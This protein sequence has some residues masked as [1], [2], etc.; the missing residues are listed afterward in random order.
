VV[1]RI[2]ATGPQ[3][4][5]P[6]VRPRLWTP[7]RL[8]QL[9]EGDTD[10]GPPLVPFRVSGTRREPQR[11]AMN[12]YREVRAIL[13]FLPTPNCSIIKFFLLQY[14]AAFRGRLSRWGSFVVCPPFAFSWRCTAGT[15]LFN[16]NRGLEGGEPNRDGPRR[17]FPITDR[18]LSP[19]LTS[20]LCHSRH[21]DAGFPH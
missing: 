19:T 7:K 15:P 11:G 13:K 10:R 4:R 1:Y 3:S 6:H 17:S 12:H 8:E 21:P 16:S 20:E 9:S 18:P 2:E 14:R 5:R